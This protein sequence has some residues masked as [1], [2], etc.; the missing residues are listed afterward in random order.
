M[1]QIILLCSTVFLL[2]GCHIY[3]PYHRP[4]V[5]TDGLYGPDVQA[6]D[7]ASIATLPWTALF[8]APWLQNLIRE[9]LASN[10]DLGIA[11]LRVR[12]AEATLLSSR[13]AYLPSVSLAP[14]GGLSS[15]DGAKT[16]KTYSL[17]ARTSCKQN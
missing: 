2:S 7:T 9:G 13:L 3:K 4:E 5:Q 11:R 6:T 10:T 12:E 14:Q 1:K 16:T 8:T 15:Y 17:A